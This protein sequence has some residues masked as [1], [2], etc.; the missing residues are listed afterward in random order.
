MKRNFWN[1]N[2]IVYFSLFFV[3]LI[4]SA[5]FAIAL[6]N[7]QTILSYAA[8]LTMLLVMPGIILCPL[9]NKEAIPIIDWVMMAFFYITFVLFLSFFIFAI[10]DDNLRIIVTALASSSIGGLLTLTGVGLTVKYTRLHREE[11]HLERIKPHIFAISDYRWESFSKEKRI[12]QVI[13]LDKESISNT[14]NKQYSYSFS[15]IYIANSDLSLSVLRGIY[16][17][18]VFFRFE[19]EVILTKDSY[20]EFYFDENI[21]KIPDKLESLELLCEDIMQNQYLVKI[22]YKILEK[23]NGCSCILVMSTY[24]PERMIN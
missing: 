2:N 17:N 15:H 7:N 9:L 3:Y 19:Y 8:G 12:I 18:D 6:F 22:G 4:S 20:N 10:A 5:V 21:F 11:E 23:N 16:L 14:Q 24:N 1:T 13:S